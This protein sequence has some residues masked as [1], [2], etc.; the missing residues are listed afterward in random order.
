MFISNKMIK[1]NKELKQTSVVKVKKSKRYNI[2][3]YNK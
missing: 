2:L 3:K 1:L